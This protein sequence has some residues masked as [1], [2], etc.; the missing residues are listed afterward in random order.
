MSPTPTASPDT[1][2]STPA[3][4]PSPHDLQ[5]LIVDDH[6][7]A[8]EALAVGLEG[9]GRY[10]RYATSAPAALELLSEFTP[11]VALVDIV[12]PEPNGIALA[13]ALRER[14]T[15]N[16]VLVAVTGE[17]LSSDA[18]SAAFA[19]FDHY[20]RKPINFAELQ[21]LLR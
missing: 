14:Y 8:A 3:A 1:P 13:H 12:M 9:E 21:L 20:L 6:E 7:D 15:N 4:A 17:G 11:H 5:I 19:V 2:S 16:I 10:I 18:Y